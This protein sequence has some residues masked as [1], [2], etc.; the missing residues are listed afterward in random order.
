[1][2]LA[3]VAGPP[4]LDEP[5]SVCSVYRTDKSMTNRNDSFLKD[6]GHWALQTQI[7]F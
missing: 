6:I 3:Q 1:M 4:I 2:F 7:S 5:E